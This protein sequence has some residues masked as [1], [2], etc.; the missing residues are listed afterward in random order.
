MA[1]KR[2]I[3][4]HGPQRCP[5]CGHE[6]ITVRELSEELRFQFFGEDVDPN[7]DYLALC[8]NCGYVGAIRPYILRHEDYEAQQSRHRAKETYR[9]QEPKRRLYPAHLIN[10]VPVSFISIHISCL[11]K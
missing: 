5:N 1:K 4:V 7:A 10:S 9:Y 2:A 11:L 8:T 3:E 6:L